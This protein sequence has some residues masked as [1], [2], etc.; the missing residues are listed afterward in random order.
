[1]KTTFL[2]IPILCL[3]VLMSCDG[4]TPYGA[5]EKTIEI[6]PGNQSELEAFSKLGAKKGNL[7]HH[8]SKEHLMLLAGK[9]IAVNR[10]TNKDEAW[11]IEIEEVDSE[12]VCHDGDRRYGVMSLNDNAFVNQDFG[13]TMTFDCSDKNEITVLLY[14]CLT[15]MK[16]VHL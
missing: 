2:F 13:V 7:R 6:N 3:A 1:M 15:F 9:Y 4:Q 5:Y 12:L 11:V 8:V 16:V 10:R 14:G